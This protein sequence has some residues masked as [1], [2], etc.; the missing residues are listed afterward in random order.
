MLSTPTTLRYYRSADAVISTGDTE[1]GTGVS[2]QHCTASQVPVM[3]SISLTAP[4]AAGTYYYGACVDPVSPERA[5]FREQ[6]FRC[7]LRDASWRA[8]AR[9]LR[10]W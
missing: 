3:R 4:S 10:I 7:C 1:V 2:E 6:L 9:V 8:A 5:G